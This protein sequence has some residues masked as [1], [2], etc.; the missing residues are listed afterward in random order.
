MELGNTSTKKDLKKD[1][2]FKDIDPGFF[3]I[4][5]SI[6]GRVFQIAVDGLIAFE[7]ED[8]KELSDASLD[9][10]LNDCSYYR[11]TF[12]SAAAE[13]EQRVMAEE[14][15]FN[16]WFANATS[17]ARMLVITERN[18]LI[19]EG[20]FAKGWFGS[21]TKQE[22]ETAIVTHHTMGDEYEA[23]QA[24]IAEMRKNIKLLTG[25]RDVLQDRGGYLQSIGRR[26]MENKKLKFLIRED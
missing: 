14:R 16:T 18:R 17:T 8:L 5:F 1:E 4:H 25:L 13:L 2:E 9:E 19:K 12:I 26:R 6:G 10:A 20:G 24:R 7:K 3:Q 15:V 22:I 23:Y 21:I 11:F